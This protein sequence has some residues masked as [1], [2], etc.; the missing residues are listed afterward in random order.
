MERESD[1]YEKLVRESERQ[2]YDHHQRA[3][4]YGYMEDDDMSDDVSIVEA[5]PIEGRRLWS[6]A[7]PAMSARLAGL[8][9]TII[10]LAFMG[11]AGSATL[12]AYSLIHGVIMKL[13]NGILVCV[14]FAL[15]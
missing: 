6:L 14:L 9:I 13:A 4:N 7:L 8:G 10:T 5:L 11:H 12:A 1:I 3:G 2:T 15:L